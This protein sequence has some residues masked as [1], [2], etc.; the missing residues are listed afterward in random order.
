MDTK[1][2]QAAI[3]VARHG[4]FTRAARELY[5]AQSTLSRQVLALERHLGTE[6]FVRGLRSVS[7][8]R[9]GEAFLPEAERVLDA[10][11]CAEKAAR[12]RAADAGDAPRSD[13]LAV[14]PDRGPRA[15]GTD[16]PEPTARAAVIPGPHGRRGTA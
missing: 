5:M 13:R 4:S 9:G 11:A 16:S 1:H 2:L 14:V 15:G 12:C 6:L 8:T 10:V 7:L 3:T